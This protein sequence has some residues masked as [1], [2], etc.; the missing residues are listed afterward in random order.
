MSKLVPLM[1]GNYQGRSYITARRLC[2]NLYPE[3]NPPDGQPPVPVT[4]YQTPGLLAL[5]QSPNIEG[6]R[7]TYRT[8]TGQLYAV[9]GPSVYAVSVTFAWTLLGTVTDSTTPLKFADNGLCIVAVDG[10]TTGYAIDMTTNSFGV[11]TD[12]S[13][14]G[15]LDAAQMDGFF[16][17]NNPGT[18]QFYI[19][20][21]YVTYAMLTGVT[22]RVLAGEILSGGSGYVSGSYP[23]VPLT[24]GTGSGAT[25]DF[26]VAGGVVTVLTLVDGGTG[27]TP[28]DVLTTSNAN[29]GGSGTGFSY[30]ADTVATAFD[31]LDIATKSGSADP[32]VNVASVHGELW[33]IGQLTSEIWA[34]SGA[35]DF[36]FQRIPGAFID[37]GNAAPYSLS[38]QD[39][40]L[41]WLSQDRQGHGIVVRSDG[42]SIRQISTHAIEQ[43]IQAY[44]NVADAIGYCHQVEGHAFYVLTFPS[45]DVTWAYDLA[46]GQWHRRASIDGNGVKH[47]H[48]AN[49]FAFAYGYNIV[50]DYQNGT[51]YSLDSGTFT[52]NGVAIPRTISFPHLTKDGQRVSYPQFMAKMEVGQ[53]A[54][55]MTDDPPQASLRWSDTGG[56]SFG[57][58]VL[59]SI[60]SAGQ[61]LTSPQWQRLGMAR[62]RI[63]E[64]SWDVN[65]SVAINGAWVQTKA[66]AT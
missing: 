56:A 51:L 4:Y 6:V 43:D 34:P 2:V 53:Y 23:G 5:S 10:S 57:D 36:Y 38:Q 31:P 13:F 14:M 22:G 17:F 24:G 39:I 16:I 20:L 50:G 45:A 40:S 15:A 52:D 44:A 26:T 32:I 46:T 42:Y 41:F 1:G 33:L 55:S 19:S 18:N 28:G 37:H 48:R 49:C 25:A 47:R 30:S 62:D 9:V 7:Q 58:A 12:P 27:F 64:L 11:I 54:G 8:T 66:F 60:G 63:F 59:Q 29:L 35:A 65:A 3:A 21:N 61:Y